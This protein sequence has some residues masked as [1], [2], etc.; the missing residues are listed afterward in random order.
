MMSSS[1]HLTGRYNKDLDSLSSAFGRPLACDKIVPLQSVCL[2]NN[3]IILL[4]A[5]TKTTSKY[6]FEQIFNFSLLPL[7]M[8]LFIWL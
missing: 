5:Y 3:N 4:V 8:T 1:S 7:L 2:S 6:L